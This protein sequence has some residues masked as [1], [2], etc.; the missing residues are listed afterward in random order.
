M[1]D[2][3]L[4]PVRSARRVAPALAVLVIILTLVVAWELIKLMFNLDKR[5]LPHLWEIAE[6]F[7][8]PS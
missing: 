5:T 3:A 8:Q 4:S 7:G 6:A 1:V 2:I